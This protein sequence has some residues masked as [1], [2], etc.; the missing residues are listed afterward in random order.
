MSFLRQAGITLVTRGSL[1]IITFA[2]NVLLA[3]KL[4]AEG[5]GVLDPLRYFA[6]LA[7]QFGNLGLAVGA[8]Y[9]IGLDRDRA[10]A[11][12]STLVTIGLLIS[13]ILFIGFVGAA[14]LMPGMLGGISLSLYTIIM[15]SVAP[16]ILFLFFQNLL[17]VYQKIIPFNMVELGVRLAI[18]IVAAILFVTTPEGTWLVAIVW[19]TVASAF[20]MAIIDGIYVWSSRTFT[21]RIDWKAFADMIGYG[22]KS[23]YSSLMVWIIMFSDIFFL[24]A[25]RPEAE[26]GIYGRAFWLAN[27][28]I[29]QVP[30]TFGTLLFPRLMQNGASAETGADE[31]S[32]FTMVIARFIALVLVLLLI[33]FAIIGRWFLG[34]FGPEFTEGYIPLLILLGG[35]VFVGIETVLAAE[36]ARRGLPIFVVAYS[37]VCVL[38]KIAAS[39][40]LIRPY[41]MYGA[42]WSSFITNFAFLALV[43]WYCVRYYGF[44]IRET[45]FIQK[46]DFPLL[47]ERIRH[48]LRR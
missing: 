38:I 9:F 43:L 4:G 26:V 28:V 8:I 11:I 30:M 20:A 45:L 27:N 3:R 6:Q 32:R 15:I 39:I 37:T 24:N 40:L 31:R 18:V 14:L 5:M 17:L 47:T 23:Y 29:Y 25:F 41:G 33:I 42:A 19:L 21:L 44:S 10:K 36:L 1:L 48:A 22:W 7:L 34:I 35:I 46:D 16:M 13:I 12:A 2:Y